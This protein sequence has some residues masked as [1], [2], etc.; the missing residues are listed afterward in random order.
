[1]NTRKKVPIKIET[2]VLT[3]SKRRCAIC[4]GIDGDLEEKQGQIAHLDKD[5]NNNEFDNL[6]FLC[7]NH[8]DRYDSKTSVSK[9]YTV[10]E[11]KSYRKIL[12]S[13]VA[14]GNDSKSEKRSNYQNSNDTHDLLVYCGK[15]KELFCGYPSIETVDT[16]GR[17]LLVGLRDKVLEFGY[18]DKLIQPLRDFENRAQIVFDV[19]LNHEDSRDAKK[20]LLAVFTNLKTEINV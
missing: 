2:D 18:D 16:K 19:I 12:Y 15:I 11:I 14:T 9:N 6:C 17:E 8:H 13:Q 1:M 20:E 4:F 5:P 3:S 10:K 7:L